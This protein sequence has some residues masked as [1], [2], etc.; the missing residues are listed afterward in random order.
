MSDR[1]AFII[2]IKGEKFLGIT[3]VE[4][5]LKFSKTLSTL[6]CEFEIVDFLRQAFISL[7]TRSNCEINSADQFKAEYFGHQRKSSIK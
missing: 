7:K 2:F 5:N 6:T 4:L 3:D 1:D